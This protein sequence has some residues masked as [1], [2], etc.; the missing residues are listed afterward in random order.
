M[1]G[2]LR[3]IAGPARLMVSA[4][5]RLPLAISSDGWERFS[6]LLSDYPGAYGIGDPRHSRAVDFYAKAYM[7]EKCDF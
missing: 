7:R 4:E 5:W 2:E 6:F 3:M 1:R